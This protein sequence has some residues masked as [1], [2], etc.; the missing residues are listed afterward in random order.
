MTEKDYKHILKD[1][2]IKYRSFFNFTKEVTFGIEIEY[3]NVS[4]QLMAH[5]IN[6]EEV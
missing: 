5:L 1:S 4:N 3:E 6:E 2:K